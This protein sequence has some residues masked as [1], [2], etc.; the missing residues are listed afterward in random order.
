[1]KKFKL[2]IEEKN[3]VGY[4]VEHSKKRFEGRVSGCFPS[5]LIGYFNNVV[6]DDVK[7]DYIPFIHYGI[8]IFRTRVMK[9]LDALVLQQLGSLIL[10]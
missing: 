5:L 6:F 10:A 4:E 8:S 1:M 3:N 9:E 2:E 7:Q